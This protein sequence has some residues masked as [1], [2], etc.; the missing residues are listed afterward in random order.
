MSARKSL[1]SHWPEYLIEAWALGMFM[2]SAGVATTVVEYPGSWLHQQLLMPVL[3]RALIGAFMGLTATALIHSSWGQ[4]SG[5]HMN[6]AV[7]L[8]FW[9]LGKMR[10]WDT[11]FYI[12][13]QCLGGILG[14]LLVLAAFGRAF[15]DAPVRYV[16]TLPGVHG[17]FVAFIAECL[18]SMGMMVAILV[19]S[20]SPRLAPYTGVIAGS[21]VALYITVEAP[22]S[23]M[24]MNPARSV[25]SAIPG[26]LWQSLWLYCTAPVIGMMGGAQLFVMTRGRERNRCAKLLHP[27]HLPCI[28]CG[29]QP[30]LD[31]AAANHR[32]E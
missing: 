5:A 4:R 11:G 28:H 30:V 13:A 22:L 12:L 6:P 8:A 20:N 15:S 16:A 3:R 7:T 17:V 31:T 21:L 14:V 27:A 1:Q 26:G 32:A 10:G 19:A 9:S 2:I 25:A 23:G 24:S 18:I 29:Q